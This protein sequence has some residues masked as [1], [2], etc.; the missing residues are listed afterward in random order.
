MNSGFCLNSKRWLDFCF[1][2]LLSCPNKPDNFDDC[3]YERCGYYEEKEINYYYKRKMKIIKSYF[4]AV[5][6]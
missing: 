1:G 5:S 2:S 6:K 4:K 3:M